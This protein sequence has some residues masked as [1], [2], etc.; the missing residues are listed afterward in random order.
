MNAEQIRDSIVATLE[1]KSVEIDQTKQKLFA[2]VNHS[3]GCVIVRSVEFVGD[4]LII[5]EGNDAKE[6]PATV[7]QHVSQ[8][9]FAIVTWDIPEEDGKLPTKIVKFR[10]EKDRPSQ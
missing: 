4:A 6:R 9:N 2:V 5:F 8:V 1:A 7:I 3:I 10:R